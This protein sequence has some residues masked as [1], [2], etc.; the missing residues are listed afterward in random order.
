M[1]TSEDG[2]RQGVVTATQTYMQATREG[3]VHIAIR[4]DGV[5]LAAANARIKADTQEKAAAAVSSLILFLSGLPARPGFQCQD[6][7]PGPGRGIQCSEVRFD[8]DSR[9]FAEVADKVIDWW[10]AL[11]RIT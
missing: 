10:D 5:R 3:T 2:T 1:I 9:Y 6:I 11:A 8:G 7:E 4:R